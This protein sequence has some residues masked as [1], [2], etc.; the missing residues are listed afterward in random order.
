MTQEELLYQMI[1]KRKSF[2]LFR[3]HKTKEYFSDFYKITNSEI[4]DIYSTF[5][6]LKPLIEDIKVELRIVENELTTCKRGQDR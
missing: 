5:K 6:T 1:S 3:E 2:H 4:D